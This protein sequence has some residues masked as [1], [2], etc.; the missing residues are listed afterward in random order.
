MYGSDTEKL[1]PVDEIRSAVASPDV[2]R[3]ATTCSASDMISGVILELEVCV[4]E[5]TQ[6]EIL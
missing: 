1:A 5:H 6:K 3:L 2:R 4:Q